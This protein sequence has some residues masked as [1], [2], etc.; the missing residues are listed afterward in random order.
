MVGKPLFLPHLKEPGKS[1]APTA[2]KVDVSE[3]ESLL[4]IKGLAAQ[5]SRGREIPSRGNPGQSQGKKV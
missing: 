3:M 2:C 5:A 4:F 1:S